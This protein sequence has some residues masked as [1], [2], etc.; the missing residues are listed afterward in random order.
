[1]SDS[2][3]DWDLEISSGVSKTAQWPKAHNTQSHSQ[4]N[5]FSTPE[6]RFGRGRGRAKSPSYNWPATNGSSSTSWRSSGDSQDSNNAWPRRP[7]GEFNSGY[8]TRNQW[9]AQSGAFGS[10]DQENGVTGGSQS[11]RGVLTIEVSSRDVGKIIGKGGQS[12]K[13]I[14]NTSGARVKILKDYADAIHT[15][16]EISG[17]PENQTKAKNMIDEIISPQDLTSKVED[18][19]TEEKPSVPRI[20]WDDLL[21]NRA[22]NQA[23]KW[24]GLPSITKAFYDESEAVRRRTDEEVEKFRKESNDIS[25]KN[26]GDDVQDR[27]IP[28]PVITFDEAFNHYP[29][30]LKELKRVGFVKP[31]PIQCQS[32]PVLLSGLNLIGIAQT[33]TGKTLAFLL[34]A[35]I[36]VDGQVRNGDKPEGPNVLVLSPTRELALQIEAEVNKLHYKG[37]RS[38]CVYGGS[39][40]RAQ[41]DTVRSGVQIVIGTVYPYR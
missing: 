25:V 21:A 6:K 22:A 14:Q 35:L 1:M 38:V 17:N 3:E 18:L 29:D 31:T 32:W 23:K 30:I 16:I 24:E 26:V 15:P 11:D 9:P 10:R 2:G 19:K 39:D 27:D 12:I 28:K 34:P 13:N 37:I 5:G 40:R 33:G 8:S 4:N 36:H 7:S 20:D 41:I